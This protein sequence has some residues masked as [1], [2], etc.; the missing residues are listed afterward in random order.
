MWKQVGVYNERK[1]TSKIRRGDHHLH[2]RQCDSHALD[3]QGHKGQYLFRLPS[4]F[5]RGGKIRGCH[6]KSRTVQETL[7]QEIAARPLSQDIVVNQSWFFV[8]MDLSIIDEAFLKTLQE[9]IAAREKELA[10]SAS[11][12][13]RNNYRELVRSH[14]RLNKI[15][16]MAGM[17]LRLKKEADECRRMI[18]DE[19]T[20][21]EMR[22]LAGEDLRETEKKIKETSNALLLELYPPDP[23][24]TRNIIM[25]IRAGTGGDEAA[26]FAGDLTRMYARHA[27]QQGWKTEYISASPSEKGGYKEIIFSIEGENVFRGLQYEGGTHRVQRVPVTEASGRIH[28][29]TATVA[30]LPEADEIDEIE[31][32]PEDIRLDVFRASGAGGQHVNKTDS[33]V[34][35]T[36]LPTGIVVASQEERSQHKNRAKAMRVLRSHLLAIKKRAS[37]Q[38]MSDSRRQQIGS[39]DRSERIRT[40]NFPQNRL[41]DHRINFTAYN[42]GEVIEGSLNQL[43]QALREHYQKRKFEQNIQIDKLLDG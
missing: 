6:R 12:A 42:L 14:A 10:E 5:H 19:N 4:I 31:I 26:L 32:K 40:Y 7:R 17:F 38:Q 24:E 33:A 16:E 27:E 8:F 41:T 11:A 43:L 23:D 9:R 18:G 21:A 39:G 3:G 30:V 25:E 29:S 22:Q 15:H 2:L 37:E 13:S 34:R 35:I 36:H 28:T 1:N 20:E